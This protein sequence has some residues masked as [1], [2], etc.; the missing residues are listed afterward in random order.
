L[1]SIIQQHLSRH[2]ERELEMASL[3]SDSFYVD[4]FAGGAKTDD[5]AVEVYE[6][7]QAIMKD[8]GF[9]L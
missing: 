8:A 9:T 3:V 1:A 2:K 7:A 5:D 4:D 6:M